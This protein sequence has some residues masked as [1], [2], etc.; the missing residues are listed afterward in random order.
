[1]LMSPDS[2]CEIEAVTIGN[3]R[4]WLR[5]GT[6]SDVLDRQALYVVGVASISNPRLVRPAQVS[7]L[8]RNITNGLGH[9]SRFHTRQ[10]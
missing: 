2:Q 4:P 9:H 6:P 7:G 10:G 5:R 1:M 3:E 8:A